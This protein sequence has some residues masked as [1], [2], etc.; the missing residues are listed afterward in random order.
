MS[1]F[2]CPL[3]LHRLSKQDCHH[4]RESVMNERVPGQTEA[5][6]TAHFIL[7]AY[8]S[9]TSPVIFEECK[10]SIENDKNKQPKESV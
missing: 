5:W 6:I 8:L 7:F 4:L 2:L 10:H 1:D 9:T 3:T